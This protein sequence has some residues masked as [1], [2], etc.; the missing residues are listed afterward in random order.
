MWL[1]YWRP[2]LVPFLRAPIREQILHLADSS[3]ESRNCTEPGFA[4]SVHLPQMT[5]SHRRVIF[6]T[7]HL[8]YT[9]KPLDSGKGKRSTFFPKTWDSHR[10]QSYD[11]EFWGGKCNVFWHRSND[12]ESSRTSLSIFLPLP[13]SHSYPACMAPDLFFTKQIGL[14]IWHKRVIRGPLGNKRDH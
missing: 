14:Q 11:P 2:R 3:L 13:V 4:S 9:Y 10:S 5:S 7:S 6:Q 12:L 8:W 1:H